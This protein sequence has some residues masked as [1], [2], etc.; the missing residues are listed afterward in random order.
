MSNVSSACSPL[1]NLFSP[2]CDQLRHGLITIAKLSSARR[3][4][5]EGINGNHPM[6]ARKVNT[7]YGARMAD[8]NALTAKQAEVL[9]LVYDGLNSKEIALR[10]GIAPA[11]VDQ[12][13]D[14]A[15][16]KL[17]ASTRIEAARI[18]RPF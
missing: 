7:G 9:E 16:R 8:A 15:R 10:L 5:E 18:C 17:G 13:A 11:T 12:R 2:V 1:K 6:L 14:G 4:S 3:S